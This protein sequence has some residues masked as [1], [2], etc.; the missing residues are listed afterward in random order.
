MVTAP[1][2][3]RMAGETQT[4]RVVVPHLADQSKVGNDHVR[5]SGW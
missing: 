3:M 1:P 5:Y 4:Y 2:L